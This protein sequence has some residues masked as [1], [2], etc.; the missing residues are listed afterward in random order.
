M[1]EKVIKRR[2]GT[3]AKV[4]EKEKEYYILL[5]TYARFLAPFYNLFLASLMFGSEPKLRSKVADMTNAQKSYRILDLATGTGKQAFAFAKMG[6]DVVGVDLSE[7]MLGVAIRANKYDNLRFEIADATR[8]PFED[9]SF[10]ISCISFALHD[11]IVSIREKALSELI[12]VTKAE[13]TIIIVDYAVPKNGFIRF[14]AY[15]IIRLFEPYYNEFIR[16]DFENLVRKSGIQIENRFPVLWG[17]GRI[18]KGKRMRT[19]LYGWTFPQCTDTKPAM[20]ICEEGQK[21]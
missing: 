1:E 21:N 3:E 4:T 20:P 18:L 16:S 19:S 17:A 2:F 13:G 15:N 5:K 8:L 9:N 14:F 11:M 10:D 12:R 7:D 6:S